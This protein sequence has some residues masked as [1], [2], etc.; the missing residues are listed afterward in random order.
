MKR[1]VTAFAAFATFTGI[2]AQVTSA[3]EAQLQAASCFPQ[4]SFFSKRFESLVEEVNERGAGIVHINYVGGAPAIGSQ[5]T[6][7]QKVAQGVYDLNSCTGSYYQNTL[8][9]ADAWK[10]LENTPTEIRENGGWDYMNKLHNAKNLEV[11]S[12]HHFGTNFY[13][14]LAP[15]HAIDKPDLSGLHLRTAPTYTNFFKSLGA[16]TQDTSITDIF[17]LMENGTVK[18]YG[19]PVLG[20]QPGWE[21]VTKYRVEPGFY[22]VDL[23]IMSNKRA[24]DGLSD[25]ARA[26]I[27]EVALNLELDAIANDPALN[28]KVAAKQVEDGFEVIEFTGAER[29]AWLSAAR[30]AGWAGVNAVSPEHGPKLREYFVTE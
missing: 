13:L 19:W 23:V 20:H 6:V 9:E 30:E 29:D 21:S 11:L 14:F 28:K 3:Q 8:P 7:V 15:G 17:T 16:T 10:L 5:L 18:G 4:G 27:S 25:E 1:L 22:D 2:G 24:W 26:L 12:R